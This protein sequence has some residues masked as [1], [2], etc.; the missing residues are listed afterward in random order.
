MKKPF[1][2]VE[3]HSPAPLGCLECISDDCVSVGVSSDEAIN[4]SPAHAIKGTSEIVCFL[5][6]GLYRNAP[7]FLPIR[8]AQV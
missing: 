5:P 1:I 6:I 4:C 2:W 8:R 3:P 7:G